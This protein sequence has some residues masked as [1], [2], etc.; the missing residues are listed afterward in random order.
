MKNIIYFLVIVGIVMLGSCKKTNTESERFKLL[1]GPTWLSDSLLVDKADAG[2]PGGLLYKFKGNAKFNTDKTGTFG[3]YQGTW[4]FAYNETELTIKS[5]SLPVILVAS[6]AELTP[7][8]LK[9]T[10][11][12]PNPL[13]ALP[14]NIRMTFK[15]K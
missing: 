13:T 9:I 1:T 2:G 14:M 3:S 15:A 10:T 6:I 7:I 11:V 8:S 4:D 5:D 12:Y